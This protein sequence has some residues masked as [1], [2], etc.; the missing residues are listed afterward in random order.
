MANGSKDNTSK[1]SSG[2]SSKG[3]RQLYLL[4]RTYAVVVQFGPKKPGFFEEAG[5]LNR[6]LYHMC[7]RVFVKG[8]MD[9]NQLN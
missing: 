4:R 9:Y 2:K 7:H 8:L 3:S 1:R 6:N 5:L